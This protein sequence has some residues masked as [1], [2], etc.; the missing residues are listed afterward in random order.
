MGVGEWDSDETSSTD[1]SRH[2]KL[3]RTGG[4]SLGASYCCASGFHTGILFGASYFLVSGF[5]RSTDGGGGGRSSTGAAAGCAVLV[6]TAK[7]SSEALAETMAKF[8]CSEAF[9][10][11]TAKL[12]SEALAERNASELESAPSLSARETGSEDGSVAAAA[13]LL[14]TSSRRVG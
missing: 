4:R 9:A 1:T 11:R 6:R 2:P 7:L 5:H 13:P 14:G 8:S 10:E 12:S 3:N